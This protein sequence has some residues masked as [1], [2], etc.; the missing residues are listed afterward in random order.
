ME[1]LGQLHREAQASGRW[2]LIVV[3]TPPSRSAL[4]FLDAPKRMGSFLEGRFMKILVAPAKMGGRAYMRL[5]TAG[6]GVFSNVLN[7]ILGAAFLQDLQAFVGAFE[8]VFSDWRERADQ[9]FALLA[10]RA[11]AFVVVAAPEPDALREASY[12]IDRLESEQMPLAGLVLN[13]VIPVRL[14]ELS[15]EQAGAG[16]ERLRD[17]AATSSDGQERLDPESALLTAALL[18]L[19]ADRM[20]SVAHQANLTRRFTRT[21]P[22]VPVAI[23]PALPWDVHDLEGLRE[24]GQYLGSETR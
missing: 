19:H 21:H 20:K 22:A 4:D 15:P 24:V 8:A 16:A 12:F 9:T 1:K 18:E 14:P 17:M 6:L 7:R 10:D 5:L 11:T 13:R 3:D 2:D 23:V